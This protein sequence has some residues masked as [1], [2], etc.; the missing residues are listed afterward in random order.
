[1]SFS[2][3]TP[4]IKPKTGAPKRPNRSKNS[5]KSGVS[6]KLQ[7]KQLVHRIFEDATEF[8][9]DTY[10]K[11]L[12]FSAS[13]NEFAQKSIYFDGEYLHKTKNRGSDS[14]EK[15]PLLDPEKACKIFIDFHQNHATLLSLE[16]LNN[17]QKERT[18]KLS[19]YEQNLLRHREIKKA[20]DDNATYEELEFVSKKPKSKKPTVKSTKALKK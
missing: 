8:T 1:M 14:K 20:Q 15:I 6:L 4:L 7:K 2:T 3:S 18:H 5:E 16:D 9:S 12:L 13:R 19:N 10:W 11:N 17:A